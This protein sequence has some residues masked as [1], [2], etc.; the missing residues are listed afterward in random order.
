MSNISNARKLEVDLEKLHSLEVRTYD[1]ENV[2]DHG[3]ISREV[4]KIMPELTCLDKDGNPVG[5]KHM[6][7]I[8]LLLAEVQRLKKMVDELD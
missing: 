2:V 7:L 4:H 8:M 3:L 1:H 5:V 6:T